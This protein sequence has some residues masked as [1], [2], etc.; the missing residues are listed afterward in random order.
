M[1]SL[2]IKSTYVHQPVFSNKR[3]KI[4]KKKVLKY[5]KEDKFS[6]PSSS[7]RSH[8][9][10]RLQ[11]A[12][13]VRFRFLFRKPASPDQTSPTGPPGP[14]WD[15]QDRQVRLQSFT[16]GGSGGGHS[17]Y[18]GSPRVG[19]QIF[20]LHQITSTVHLSDKLT[21]LYTHTTSSH[22]LKPVSFHVSP[23]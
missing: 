8:F 5:I 17:G 10:H 12:A 4:N 14:P 23:G 13:E 6:T 11:Q 20:L 15:R 1:F 3:R 18:L 21:C 22:K 19:I 16:R 2:R 7:I 9:C